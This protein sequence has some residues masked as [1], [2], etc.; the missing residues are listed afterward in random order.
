MDD[1]RKKI[2]INEIIYWKENRMLPEHY[3]N[4]LLSLYTEGNRSEEEEK[5]A[6]NKKSFPWKV[7]GIF[8]IIIIISLLFIYF[9]ELSFIWQMVIIFLLTGTAIAAAIYLYKRKMAF[10]VTLII[11]ALLI[12][13][14]SVEIVSTLLSKE[15]IFIYLTVFANCLLWVLSGWKLKLP[16]FTISGVVGFVLLIASLFFNF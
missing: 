3:C 4:Y 15:T 13:I 5:A 10:Q 6:S 11:A 16:Y 12:L 1:Q 9:T 14:G 8:A 7:N 2:I